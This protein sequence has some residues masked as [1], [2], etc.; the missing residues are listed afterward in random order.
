M[1]S[2]PTWKTGRTAAT[3]AVRLARPL[4]PQAAGQESIAIAI[5][6]YIFVCAQRKLCGC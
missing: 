6:I 2:G 5:V 1:L 3:A 4:L